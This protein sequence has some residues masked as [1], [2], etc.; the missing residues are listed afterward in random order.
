MPIVFI[1]QNGH[2]FTGPG[3]RERI[4]AT[5]PLALATE[6]NSNSSNKKVCNFFGTVDFLSGSGMMGWNCILEL[7]CGKYPVGLLG[8]SPE[9]RPEISNRYLAQGDQP[10]SP[11]LCSISFPRGSCAKGR[12]GGQ[13]AIQ[14]RKIHFSSK[15]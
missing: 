10:W 8:N 11:R 2:T 1:S 12:S 7:K 13:E 5:Y 15:A 9:V 14:E 6:F 3:I 4:T